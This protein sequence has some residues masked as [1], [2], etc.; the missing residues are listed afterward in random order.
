MFITSRITSPVVLVIIFL[1]TGAATAKPTYDQL[2]AELE[3]VKKERDQLRIELAQLKLKLAKAESKE[4]SF[5]LGESLEPSKTEGLGSSTQI[6]MV[7]ITSNNKPDTSAI[8]KEKK[9]AQS[10]RSNVSKQVRDAQ[11]RVDRMAY[12]NARHKRYYGNKKTQPYHSSAVAKARLE[13]TKLTARLRAEERKIAKA[14]REIVEANK[15]REIGARLATG[16]QIKIIAR[17]NFLSI[18]E[19]MY[20][21]TRYEIKGFVRKVGTTQQIMMTGAT[22][23]P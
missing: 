2:A 22:A 12:E 18:A 4:S 6:F 17:G 7:T 13:V 5:K 14:D 23:A 3:S 19:N 8:A 20:V 10:D 15:S 16:E 21:G 1:A 9:N 11:S